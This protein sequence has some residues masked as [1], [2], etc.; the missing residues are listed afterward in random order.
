LGKNNIEAITNWELS[1]LFRNVQSFSGVTNF[2]WRLLHDFSELCWP[3]TVSARS[4]KTGWNRT[5]EMEVAFEDH[6]RRFD[7]TMILIY[8][9]PRKPS[10]LET[11]ASDLALGAIVSDTDDGKMLHPVTFNFRKF[12]LT[13]IKYEV[14]Y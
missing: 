4:N 9:S 8:F 3:L 12:Q 6:K 10:I 5:P 2:Y 1:K 13:I 11:D 14:Y 7:L